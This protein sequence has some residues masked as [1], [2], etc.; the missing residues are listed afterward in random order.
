[1]TDQRG[2]EARLVVVHEDS[3]CD[4]VAERGDLVIAVGAVAPVGAVVAEWIIIHF[5]GLFYPEQVIQQENKVEHEL[6]GQPHPAPVLQIMLTVSDP[7][8]A[9]GG[10]PLRTGRVR[11]GPREMELTD[12]SVDLLF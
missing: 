1:M 3:F 5:V 4:V 12:F 7:R 2:F 10:L 9:F 8:L 6:L 11:V